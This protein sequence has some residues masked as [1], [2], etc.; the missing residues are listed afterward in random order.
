MNFL[1]PFFLLGLLAVAIPVIIHLINLRRPQKV[2]FSTLS[3]LNELKKSTIR[4]IRIKQY[5]LMTLRALAVLFLALALA[6]PFL[7]PT[8]TGTSGSESPKTIGILVD[9][10]PSMNRIGTRGPLIEQARD[11]ATT[12]I[13]G[14]RSE[15]R[16]IVGT[17]NGEQP[18]IN[19][20]GSS[21]ALERLSGIEVS[22]TGNFLSEA[23]QLLYE[24]LQQSPAEQAV[25]YLISDGQQ[26]QLE[27]LEQLST[28][29]GTTTAK[30]ISFQLVEL[31]DVG[32]QNLAVSGLSLQGQM[33][34]SG[35]PAVLQVEVTNVGE[36]AAVNQFVSLELEDRMVGQ[37]QVDL[38]PGS[39]QEFLFEI[40]PDK[41][42][43]IP[44]EILLDGDEVTYDNSRYFVLRIPRSRSVLLL[45]EEETSGS[46]FQSYLKPALE[47]ARQTNTQIV[48]EEQGTEDA[49][50]SNLNT[51]DVVVLDGLD[52]IPEYWFDDLQRF[53]QNGKGILFF[54]SEQGDVNNYNSFFRLFNAGTFRNVTGE[55]ASFRAVDEFDELVEGHPILDQLF[56]KE[57]GEEIS[58]DL[59]ELFFYFNY[60]LPE[61][62]G[63]FTVLRSQNGAPL[64]T[65]QRFGE[66]RLLVSAYGTDPGWTNF[67]VNPLFA[68]LYY[69]TVLYASS[70]EQ[71][72]F[73]Q[74]TLGR[75]FEWQGELQ[76]GA[77]EINYGEQVVR[78]EVQG[79]PEGV[80]IS[81]PGREWTPGI[82]TISDGAD[83][84]LVAVN[85]YI[86]ESYFDTLPE[87]ELEKMLSNH[88]NV[89]NRIAAGEIS[90][91]NLEEELN[92]A[93][94]GKEIW[95]WF[96]WLALLLLIAEMMVSKLYKAENTN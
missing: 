76:A 41:V 19:I 14:A 93:S 43:D 24:R 6:R 28:P 35:S 86:M 82:Y 33:L 84:R 85:Q 90:R 56:E 5:L 12:I 91:Q 47:A 16:F 10:S 27:D 11:I 75:P 53:V 44:G 74:H 78:P 15:D 21:G 1:N 57:E 23:F 62:T 36:V 72:G 22:N 81:Y 29:N 17:T 87:Q 31:G 55:Y 68:P 45:T 65:E 92:A 59:P 26:S 42:G 83:K 51:Y 77:V 9:N 38:E 66:G 95:S 54:P 94:F 13:E 61:N 3:F 79:M 80:R 18:T 67:P 49:D 69:R 37:Y 96:V 30:N 25:I 32:Q 60:E 46:D 73:E 4:R 8:L 70:S 40:V 20:Q 71:G 39:S 50:Q 7:P 34:S 48:F 2:Q 52:Q 88:V 64:L 58:L 63:S 89:N